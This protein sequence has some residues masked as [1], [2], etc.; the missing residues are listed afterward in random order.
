MDPKFK[1]FVDGFVKYNLRR[2][3]LKWK[4][5]TEAFRNARIDRGIYKCNLCGLEKRSK[6][7]QLD[8]IIPVVDPTKGFTTW[9]D[10]IYRLFV[11][12]EQFQ[13]VCLTC[14]QIKTETEKNLK[15]ITNKVLDKK[16]KK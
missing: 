2:A 8:H 12:A 6:E 10:Y 3:S 11:K 15:S 16:D 9:D 1:K 14:H 4:Y 5:R 7:I 13:V